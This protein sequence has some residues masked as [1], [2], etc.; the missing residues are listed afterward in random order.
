[1]PKVAERPSH[2]P[3][4]SGV[5][6]EEPGAS[7]CVNCGRIYYIEGLLVAQLTFEGRS[8][9]MSALSAK[10]DRR[11]VGARHT[12]TEWDSAFT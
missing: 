6:A 10:V 3:R 1:M 9:M 11:T 4:C 12:Y 2:C 8:G 7:R 5:L